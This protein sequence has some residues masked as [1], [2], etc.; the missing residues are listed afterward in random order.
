VWLN[1]LVLVYGLVLALSGCRAESDTFIAEV[2]LV[3]DPTEGYGPYQVVVRTHGDRAVKRATL[4]WGVEGTGEEWTT[5]MRPS[6]SDE[7]LRSALIW[8][9][10]R[11]DV[12]GVAYREPFVLGTRIHYWVR[13]ESQ[14]GVVARAPLEAPDETFEFVVGPASQ[15]VVPWEVS[16]AIGPSSGGTRVFVRGDGFRPDTELIFGASL[17]G[18]VVYHTSHLLEVVTPPAG[19][20]LAELLVRNPTGASGRLP[21]AFFFVP[22]PRPLAVTPVS[23]PSAGGTRIT[24][25]GTEFH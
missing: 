15:P 23:G 25:H 22:P 6:S 4:R 19:P 13:V 20:G 10:T 12:D 24:I 9:P 2:S 21:D 14:E 18:D 8:A 7:S 5:F 3:G 16:P 1:R 17:A 11:T